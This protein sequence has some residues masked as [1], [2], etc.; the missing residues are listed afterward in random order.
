MAKAVKKAPD[1]EQGNETLILDTEVQDQ[2]T[3]D[4]KNMTGQP[5][6]DYV[7]HVSKISM[8]EQRVFDVFKVDVAKKQRYPGMKG[9]P[10]DVLGFVIKND[11]PIHTTKMQ[12]RDANNL[13]G[14]V[15]ED[16]ICVSAQFEN[17]KRIYLLKK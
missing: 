8:H 3:F 14:I 9:S 17:T 1:Q 2:P 12:M 15:I 4:Y 7:T 13:N 5:F 16:G 10:V 11:T 6:I